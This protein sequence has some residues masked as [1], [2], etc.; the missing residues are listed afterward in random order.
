MGGKQ[1]FVFP[2][3]LQKM[4]KKAL[5]EFQSS[6]TSSYSSSVNGKKHSA[7]V[8]EAERR[9]NGKGVRVSYADTSDTPA[10]MSVEKVADSGEISV[11]CHADATDWS[12][13]SDVIK[14][15]SLFFT[16]EVRVEIYP[17]YLVKEVWEKDHC[18]KEYNKEY[19]AF[20]AY[21][22]KDY[23]KIFVDETETKDS[24][25]WVLLHELAHIS[26]ASAPYMF[27]GYRHL[28]PTDYH[29][30]DDAHERDPEEK[31][32]NEIAT[33]WMDLLGYGMVS[34]PR[35][36]WRG[37][38]IINQSQTIDKTASTSVSPYAILR[39]YSRSY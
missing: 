7:V 18:G 9:K 36:W 29:C 17:R 12:P 19:Y 35:P 37:R 20:R 22:G 27:K 23:C 11:Y 1:V 32:A 26:L 38:T 28:T 6:S 13:S 39:M 16:K 5:S 10:V 24:A 2:F 4:I 33:S 31:M 30:S 8:E 15:L 14:R 3:R 34:Y 21:A 25:L